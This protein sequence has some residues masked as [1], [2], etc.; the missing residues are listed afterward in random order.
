PGFSWCELCTVPILRS[1]LGVR[2]ERTEAPRGDAGTELRSTSK[3]DKLK[4]SAK[5]AG[6]AARIAISARAIVK[7]S[8]S[9]NGD[10]EPVQGVAETEPGS[11]AR[12]AP[13]GSQ[14]R[15]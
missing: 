3:I 6:T 2:E 13:V 15:G 8:A 12:S 5:P 4:G 7:G 1:V 14:T 10:N 11:A 9:A